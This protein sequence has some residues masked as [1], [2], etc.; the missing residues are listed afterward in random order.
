MTLAT[1][2]IE[3]RASEI[4]EFIRHRSCERRFKLEANKRALARELPFYERLFNTLDVVLQAAGHDRE[5]LWAEGLTNSGLIDLVDGR[6]ED[7]ESEYPAWDRF[8]EGASQLAPGEQAFAREVILSGKIGA[9]KVTGRV[10]FLLLLWRDGMPTLR[11]VECKGSRRDRTYHRIQVSIYKTILGQLLEELPLVVGGHQI[12]SGGVEAV[13]ARIDETTNDNQDILALEPLDLSMEESDVARLLAAD[14]QLAGVL[15]KDLE[16][17][18]FRIEPKCDGC[19]FSVHCLSESGRQRR[20]ELTGCNVS[21]ALVLRG[22]GIGTI[23]DL[24]KLDAESELAASIRTNPAFSDDLDQ[25]IVRAK[26]RM[27]TLPGAVRPS[28]GGDAY[29]VEPLPNAPQSQLPRHE[30]DGE[31]LIRVYLGVDYDYTENRVGALTAHVTASEGEL[32]TG[33]EQNSQTGKWTP[34]PVPF[35]EMPAG[36]TREVI[37]RDVYQIKMSPWSGDYAQDTGAEREL[38]QNFLGHLIGSIAEIAGDTDLGGAGDGLARIHFYVWSRS[39]M[40]Q[41]IEACSRASSHLL[42]ALRELLGCRNGL[43]Q[44][45][46]SCLQEE[47]DNRYTFGWTGRGLAVL[48][49]LT[50]FGKRFHW[51]RKVNGKPVP[52]DVAFTQDLFDFKTNLWLNDDGQWCREGHTESGTK[53]QFEIRSR[54]HDTLPAPYWHAQWASLPDPSD[55]SLTKEAKRAIKRYQDAAKPNMLPAYLTAR[56]QALRWVDERVRFKNEELDKPRLVV[57][58][59]NV[60]TLG[61]DSV[62]AAAVDFLRLDHAVKMTDWV[63]RHLRSVRGRL[64]GGRTIPL[65]NVRMDSGAMVADIDLE[66]YGVRVEDLEAVCSLAPGSFVR[67][68]PS[69]GDPSRGQTYRQLVFGGVTCKIEDLDWRNRRIRLS[70]FFS[71]ESRYILKSLFVDGLQFDHA[72]ADESVT[73]FVAGRVDR[74]LMSGSGTHVQEWFDPKSPAVPSVDPIS[75]VL[76]DHLN[77]ALSTTPAGKI[78]PILAAD[79]LAAVLAGLDSRIQLLQGPP[80]TGKTQTTAVAVLAQAAVRLK[81]GDALLIAAHTHTAVDTLLNRIHEV[82]D[83]VRC[84]LGAAGIDLPEVRLGKVQSAGTEH[85][86]APVAEDIPADSCFRRVKDLT[87]GAVGVLGGTTG[88]LL[89]MFESLDKTKAWSKLGGFHVPLLVVDEASMMVFP[90]FLALAT[91]VQPVGHVLLAGDHRQLSPIVANDWERED[92]PPAVTYQPYVSAYAAVR[93]IAEQLPVASVATTALEMSFRLP[94]AIINLLSRLYERDQIQLKG[95]DL[96]SPVVPTVPDPGQGTP[97]LEAVWTK[98]AGLYLVVHDED[99]SRQ[100]NAFEAGLIDRIVSLDPTTREGSTAVLT[101]HR[102]QR[103]LLTRTLAGQ[104]SVGVVDTVER[105]QGGEKPTVIV[106]GT[107]SE[108]NAI[109]QTDEFLMDLNRTNVAFSRCQERLIVVCSRTLLGHVPAELEVYESAMLWKSLRAFCSSSVAAE[110]INGH[111]IQ[112]FTVPRADS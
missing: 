112:V 71:M 36:G 48:T 68:S 50:W 44:L 41:L 53:G 96:E 103:S 10:D 8:V 20:L 83:E 69:S 37:G 19:V 82:E 33:F 29:P 67:V 105:L 2:G 43:E 60:F 65:A 78:H 76:R 108:P 97:G 90:H 13:V 110:R 35:E 94:R 104:S 99:G 46:Y 14:G 38:L 6:P 95:I 24:A 107:V 32:R 59:L 72:T 34:S 81:R 18:G 92:R 21:S 42:G 91:A 26:A 93:Q 4:G 106:S 5:D 16:S 66:P 39:E 102:A 58:E 23:D 100:S 30:I 25:L 98:G 62:R 1:G 11:V 63:G 9:F 31:R 73:D 56:S 49:S 88:A 89:K 12:D 85:S 84:A 27:A 61:I 109:A 17:I 51:T 75:P 70:G 80:G 74:R 3:L 40:S 64:Y 87:D 86:I 77:T 47:V 79:Q 15:A 45:I 111:L 57:D 7:R 28:E 55:P 22:V 52:L 54:F 101:P